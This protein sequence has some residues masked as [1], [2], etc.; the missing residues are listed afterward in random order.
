MYCFIRYAL[1]FIEHTQKLE[2]ID[3]EL[4]INYRLFGSECRVDHVDKDFHA[5]Y[6]Q[7]PCTIVVTRIP[8]NVNE[9]E[10]LS[11]FVG[12]QSLKYYSGCTAHFMQ[13]ESTKIPH[14]KILSGYIKVSCG[15]QN[16][17]IGTFFLLL[18]I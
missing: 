4:P 11:I 18:R 15:N 8:E 12:C 5:R 1:L 3:D 17:F 13:E 10:L 16:N 7:P 14:N 2:R 6:K 9:N